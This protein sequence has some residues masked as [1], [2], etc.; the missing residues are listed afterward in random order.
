MGADALVGMTGLPLFDFV[1]FFQ[2]N[3]PELVRVLEVDYKLIEELNNVAQSM[4]V[5][6][7]LAAFSVSLAA[8]WPLLSVSL[9]A[10]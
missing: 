4:A 6:V 9:A 1:L 10:V 8:I 5:S 2:K 7:S 3:T